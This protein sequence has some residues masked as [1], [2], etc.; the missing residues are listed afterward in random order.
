MLRIVALAMFAAIPCHAQFAF[1]GLLTAGPITYFAVKP[2]DHATV[3]VQLQSLVNGWRIAA[4]DADNISLTLWKGDERRVLV[5]R[6]S[7]NREP[8]L[9]TRLLDSALRGD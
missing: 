4:F 8:E 2:P 3:F 7:V 6:G 9:L 1:E 5:L